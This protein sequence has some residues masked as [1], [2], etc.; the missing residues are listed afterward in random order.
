M[1]FIPELFI[2]LTLKSKLRFVFE[3]LR[4]GLKLYTSKLIAITTNICI[5]NAGYDFQL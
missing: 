4:F 1:P 2:D 3:L 5:Y